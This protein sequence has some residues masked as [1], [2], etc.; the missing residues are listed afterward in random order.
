MPAPAKRLLVF[1]DLGSIETLPPQV[2]AVLEER[3]KLAVSEAP[4]A[5]RAAVDE[6][7]ALDTISRLGEGVGIVDRS[8]EI[9]WMNAR[10]SGVD[11]ELLRGFADA[12]V[13]G[14]QALAAA[15]EAPPDGAR[16]PGSVRS[17]IST[18]RGEYEVVV[19][20]LPMAKGGFDRAIGLLLDITANRRLERRIETVD[21]AGGDLL[22]LDSGVV[23]LGV[24][25]RLRDLESRIVRG[26]EAIV[27]V[28]TCEVRLLD[29]RSG[30]LELVMARQIAPLP[31]G[32][33]LFASA[34]GQGISGLVAA[35][36]QGYVCRDTATDPAYVP[37]LVGARSSVTVPIRRG[38]EL[39]GIL[40]VESL[41]PNRFEDE[42]RLC[43]ELF[44]RYIGLAMTILDMLVVER[45]TTNRQV[46]ETVLS[47][48]QTPIAAIR[49]AVEQL[50]AAPGE[51]AAAGAAASAIAEAL[52]SLEARL[53]TSTSGPQ[54]ILGAEE[55][56]RETTLDQSLA[57]KSVLVA[58]D[59][60][61]IR[62]T[63][64]AILE[65]KGCAVTVCPDGATAI[66]EILRRGGDRR[67]ELVIS[68][69]RMPDRNG[70]EVFRAA[71]DVH[72]ETPVILMTGFG[73]DPHHSI[74][75]SSQEGLHCFLF[76]P[77]QVRQLLDEVQ[78]ALLEGSAA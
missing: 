77:F 66:E 10:L 5:R 23:T 16:P 27:G 74:V 11:P 34:T 37:G 26:L 2:R 44:G 56:L 68:D 63:I 49:A 41:E 9:L 12:C 28:G 71:K 24:T 21:A 32:E 45:F 51:A 43:L 75:R 54:S 69:V 18:P 76:K 14:L 73:Y 48:L 19:T 3:F 78:K 59:E 52:A 50:R 22:D 36:G 20:V 25:E 58:D 65:R 61:E 42:D 8:G 13:E 38:D 70:Y 33:R 29:R 31:I 17:Q 39:I 46:A 55:F 7:A 40:N 6:A 62:Q 72:P 67:F 30:Q 53:R 35:T 1:P 15:A 57:G 47:E 4:P 64:R 60:P